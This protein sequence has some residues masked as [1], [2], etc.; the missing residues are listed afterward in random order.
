MNLTYRDYL[1]GFVSFIQFSQ[2]YS[3]LKI[4][5]LVRWGR[6][7]VPQR[8]CQHFFI[9]LWGKGFQWGPRGA[10]ICIFH[11]SGLALW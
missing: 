11:A 3:V 1:R 7:G 10:A 9:W 6:T 2:L 5:T 8:L 4:S